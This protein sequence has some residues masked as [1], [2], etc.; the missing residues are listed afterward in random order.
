[1][2]DWELGVEISDAKGGRILYSNFL[3][4]VNSNGEIE[5]ASISHYIV[6]ANR[7]YKYLDEEKIIDEIYSQFC[8]FEEEQKEEG[9]K[10]E[11]VIKQVLNKV[12]RS[13]VFDNIENTVKG[14]CSQ[15]RDLLMN[16]GIYSKN[17]K[18]GMV[19]NMSGKVWRSPS[20]I[21]IH[22]ERLKKYEDCMDAVLIFTDVITQKKYATKF[23]NYF[24]L[25]TESSEKI[26]K[27][28]QNQKFLPLRFFEEI[29]D[30]TK[31]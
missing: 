21:M 7:V 18:I 14:Q 23:S 4:F 25:D 10:G 24:G 30:E 12:P 9:E 6:N 20:G 13:K 1:M 27:E 15:D 31:K 29:K 17:K 11:R 19:M 26:N 8:K 5:H 2:S 3:T 16:G 28:C 22:I